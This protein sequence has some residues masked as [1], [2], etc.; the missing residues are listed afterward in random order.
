M[1]GTASTTTNVFNKYTFTGNNNGITSGTQSV[2]TAAASASTDVSPKTDMNYSPSINPSWLGRIYGSTKGLTKSLVGTISNNPDLLQS[3]KHI[4]ASALR[5]AMGDGDLKTKAKN[6]VTEIVNKSSSDGFI[7]SKDQLEFDMIKR[8]ADLQVEVI[9]RLENA[10]DAYGSVALGMS[11]MRN[12]EVYT[13]PTRESLLALRERASPN[14]KAN[15]RIIMDTVGPKLGII[16]PNTT[17][18]PHDM[19][20]STFENRMTK[21]GRVGYVKQQAELIAKEMN[22]V[23]FGPLHAPAS[24]LSEAGLLR[25]GTWE[26][27]QFIGA[28]KQ[29]SLPFSAA[30]YPN[31]HRFTS[32]DLISLPSNIEIIDTSDGSKFTKFALTSYSYVLPEQDDT[33]IVRLSMSGQI[34]I[35]NQVYD[36][37]KPIK[38][39]ML[40]KRDNK[41]YMNPAIM[42]NTDYKVKPKKLVTINPVK[43]VAQTVHDDHHTF[44][45]PDSITN[46]HEDL[47]GKYINGKK[48][49]T[50]NQWVDHSD[51]K[52]Q[53]KFSYSSQWQAFVNLTN[54]SV[55]Q[56]DQVTQ[57][58]WSTEVAAPPVRFQATLIAVYPEAFELSVSVQTPVLNITVVKNPLCMRY[59]GTSYFG[60]VI[61]LLGTVPSWYNTQDPHDPVRLYY[62]TIAPMINYA[63]KMASVHLNSGAAYQLTVDH[64]KQC[65]VLSGLPALSEGDMRAHVLILMTDVARWMSDAG[66]VA[67]YTKQSR[68]LLFMRIVE[69]VMFQLMTHINVF[70]IQPEAINHHYLRECNDVNAIELEMDK[71]RIARN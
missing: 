27:S 52:K 62:L 64:V 58:G 42:I 26:T 36:P 61:D 47:D 49:A 46:V 31:G 21:Y 40:F 12:N 8:S 38:L 24:T 15:E 67:P 28:I 33:R 14:E 32:S 10:H 48:A 63:G 34:T 19:T 50:G 3:V 18:P 35:T 20:I 1:G 39:G 44:Y 68:K 5:V 65:R 17:A 30:S 55:V 37:S 2:G 29:S 25:P 23:R 16:T 51:A 13:G 43:F 60:S 59:I 4:G 45:N 54:A 9:N 70:T 6:L 71:L 22:D 11:G 57:E 66:P 69:K 56:V 7:T 41:Y 53:A